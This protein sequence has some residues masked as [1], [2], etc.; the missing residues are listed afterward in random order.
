[1]AMRQNNQQVDAGIFGRPALLGRSCRFWRVSRVSRAQALAFLFLAR[2]E[3]L[4]PQPVEARLLTKLVDIRVPRRGGHNP[5]RDR[6]E[7]L[8]A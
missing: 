8:R 1:M 7:R 2:S 3:S 5:R 4:L 6:L